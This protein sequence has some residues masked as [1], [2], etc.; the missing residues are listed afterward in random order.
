MW[1]SADGAK[2]AY[3]TFDDSEVRIMRVPH[4]GVPGSV[5]YQY[6]QHHEIR[7]P[8]VEFAVLFKVFPK[9]LYSS[10]PNYGYESEIPKNCCFLL[11]CNTATKCMEQLFLFE[12]SV[13]FFFGMVRMCRRIDSSF[14]VTSKPDVAGLT[15]LVPTNRY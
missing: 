3:V 2:L 8:K 12:V 9:Y 15:W 4:Y 1:F 14:V 13:L 11:N 5:E 7:Y 6:T 10:M